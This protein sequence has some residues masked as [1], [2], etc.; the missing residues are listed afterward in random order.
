[1]KRQLTLFLATAMVLIFLPFAMTNAAEKRKWNN[2][3]NEKR[4]KEALKR[5]SE[6]YRN[7]AKAWQNYD[8]ELGK[9]QEDVRRVR[10]DAI[11]GA[12]KGSVAGPGG[13]AVGAATGAAKGAAKGIYKRGKDYYKE[14][15]NK[16]H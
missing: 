13:A 8:R 16:K 4:Y 14:H 2:P 5:Q 7:E 12:V 11:K 3:E 6:A 15:K 9:A 1:M 10:N